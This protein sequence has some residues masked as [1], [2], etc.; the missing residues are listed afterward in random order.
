[1][2][3]QIK[4]QLY[5]KALEERV[6]HLEELKRST[7][8]RA[9]EAKTNE[10]GVN[11]MDWALNGNGTFDVASHGS[12]AHAK[13]DPWEVIKSKLDGRKQGSQPLDDAA[14]SPEL[15][16]KHFVETLAQVDSIRLQLLLDRG[17]DEKVSAIGVDMKGILRSLREMIAFC[18]AQ[19]RVMEAVIAVHNGRVD[20]RG[21]DGLGRSLPEAL[22]IQE[23]QLAS[24]VAL[25]ESRK[26]ELERT[27]LQLQITGRALSFIWKAY[28]NDRLRCDADRFNELLTSKQVK[29]V[30][31]R[32][33]K[34][35][36]ELGDRMN[37]VL[38]N[39]GNLSIE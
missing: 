2:L 17:K 19:K 9:G 28:M 25:Y 33:A 34:W 5:V 22:G 14:D 11:N 10:S 31:N 27:V 23:A 32:V 26:G 39:M 36:G 30:L 8:K 20:A 3:V 15:W 24:I 35:R 29:K 37:E 16:E 38:R 4:K 1:M 21:T 13:T 7:W 18:L 12:C 6:A